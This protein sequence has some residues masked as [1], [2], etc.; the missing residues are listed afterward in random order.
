MIAMR[1]A[2]AAT[3]LSPLILAAQPTVPREAPHHIMVGS[4]DEDYLRY[5]QIAGLASLYPW[6]LREFSQPEPQLRCDA[7][8]GTLLGIRSLHG[9]FI[10]LDRG[11]A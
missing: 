10:L 7:A 4:S 11:C 3:A 2:L 8:R 6:S 9:K 1:I 5:L